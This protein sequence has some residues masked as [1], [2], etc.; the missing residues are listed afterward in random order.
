M[1]I[2]NEYI[3]YLRYVRR[4]SSRTAEIYEEVLKGFVRYCVDAEDGSG[5]AGSGLPE[6]PD[7]DYPPF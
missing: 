1:A 2:L 6:V 5:S 7:E 4:Y 3:D